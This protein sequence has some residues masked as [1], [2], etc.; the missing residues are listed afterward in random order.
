[1]CWLVGVGT[2]KF[3]LE[4]DNM[5][6]EDSILLLELGLQEGEVLLTLL[7]EGIQRLYF[8]LFLLNCRL[9]LL[10]C[11][12]LSLTLHPLHLFDPPPQLSNL[13]SLTRTTA[14]HLR[15]QSLDFSAFSL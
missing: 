5:G 8:H 7:A 13:F 4:L 12:R 11:F 10:Y 9:H 15:S 2:L 1:M 14:G 6:I 3:G